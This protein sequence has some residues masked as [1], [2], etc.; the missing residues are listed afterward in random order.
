MKIGSYDTPYHSD[1]AVS[2]THEVIGDVPCSHPNEHQK[3]FDE[4]IGCTG[5]KYAW[6][7]S[8][9]W[10]SDR[11]RV[12][13]L[14][15]ALLKSLHFEKELGAK[16]RYSRV[17]RGFLVE[18]HGPEWAG[19]AGEYFGVEVEESDGP[20]PS[21]SIYD[22]SR[23]N[24]YIKKL[25]LRVCYEPNMREYP[26]HLEIVMDRW[27]ST[28]IHGLGYIA[29]ISASDVR[30]LLMA[31]DE[32]FRKNEWWE[33]PT[34]LARKVRQLRY[35]AFALGRLRKPF[36]VAGMFQV[37]GAHLTPDIDSKDRKTQARIARTDYYRLLRVA[38]KEKG[39]SVSRK[40][41]EDL[42]EQY[43]AGRKEPE[44]SEE[45]RMSLL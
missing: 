41:Q 6:F 32:I 44:V 27:Y 2:H 21:D 38:E 42:K 8:L 45:E 28:S 11:F 1:S 24:L 30:P 40:I 9:P 26:L 5:C 37:S 22:E 29:D 20:L 18:E 14:N 36:T 39:P 17:I 13:N 15:G 35:A 7:A 4:G 25:R 23:P 43:E 16:P 3:Y 34:E 10:Q 12:E 33:L 19:Y 31:R